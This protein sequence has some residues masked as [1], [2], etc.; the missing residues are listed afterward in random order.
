MVDADGATKFSDLEKLLNEIE[1]AI[2][3]D[4]AVVVGSR[5]HLEQEAIAQVIRV[6]FILNKR[7]HIPLE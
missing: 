6:I 4:H 5:H 3:G 1:T 7:I 2:K